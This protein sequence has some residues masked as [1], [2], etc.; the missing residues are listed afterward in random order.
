MNFFQETVPTDIALTLGSMAVHWYGVI[1][2]A[3][4]LVGFIIALYAAKKKQVRADHLYNLFFLL[5]FFCIVGGRI[6]HVI[7]DVG[8]YLDHPGKVI[9]FWQGGLA[10]HGVVL[11][12]LLT[13][14]VYA[15]VKRIRFWVITDCIVL[16]LPLMQAIGRWGNYF[17]QE[18]YGPPTNL[19]WAIMI[20]SAHR[21]PGY[22]TS[23]LFHP[24]FLYESLLML[25]I[26][27]ILFSVFRSQ[28][29]TAGRLTLLYFILWAAVRFMLD[30]LRIGMLEIGPLLLTQWISMALLIG[31]AGLWLRFRTA[32]LPD[33]Y[34][35]HGKDPEE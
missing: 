19:P 32:A 21:V 34:R 33:V 30:F 17:N 1:L 31:A 20:D 24:L 2:A 29:L 8:Y 4:V 23:T 3:A 35:E 26:F 27:G 10:F 7:G 12:G 15:R 25:I 28:R 18:L 11:A 9:A 5:T 22:G 13:A 16:G 14:I 6:G